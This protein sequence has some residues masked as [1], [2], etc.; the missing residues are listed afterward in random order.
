MDN[1]LAFHELFDLHVML[2]IV[3]TGVHHSCVMGRMFAFDWACPER[4]WW[5]TVLLRQCWGRMFAFDRV[6][7]E[8]SCWNIVLR[9]PRCARL[10]R[11]RM[12][13]F[14]RVC[15][16]KSWW[17]IVLRDRPCARLVRRVCMVIL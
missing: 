8:K 12:F 11:G 6:C 2:N 3:Q 17:K 1:V 7:P 10:V 9:D 4:T 14:N 16:E 5:D 13:A 15:P